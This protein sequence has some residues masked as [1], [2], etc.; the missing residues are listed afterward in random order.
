MGE[1][2]SRAANVLTAITGNIG[3]NGGYAA[4]FMRAYSSRE[5]K[6][7][8]PQD[9]EKPRDKS[10]GIPS[11]NPVEDGALPRKDSLYKLTGGTNSTSARMHYTKVYDAIIKGRSG[12][13]PSDL[14]MAYIV[15]SNCIN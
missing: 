11:G 13:Y 6:Y 15:G 12:G 1:Q 5:M 9:S 8:R 14:K 10:K 2:Y 3:I 4:G 7:I